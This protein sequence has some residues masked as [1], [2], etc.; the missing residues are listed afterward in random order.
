MVAI[1]TPKVLTASLFSG[2]R[3]RELQGSS[4]SS[5]WSLSVHPGSFAHPSSIV[6]TAVAF[7]ASVWGAAHTIAAVR[8][9]VYVYTN[10]IGLL[11][12]L[13]SD[14]F[15]V[16]LFALVLI[17]VSLIRARRLR[18]WGANSLAIGGFGWL[19]H[20][21]DSVGSGGESH[22]IHAF[23]GVLFSLVGWCWGTRFGPKVRLARTPF[24]SVEFLRTDRRAP[25][26]LS[27][28]VR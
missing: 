14:W 8:A 6:Q 20:V 10:N 27:R 15:I 16:L 28:A 19:Y 13:I 18:G 26:I 22:P 1:E 21:S 12:S 5:L 24:A 17:G 25:Y 3:G 23:F 7:A 2:C 4:A 9:V 11:P